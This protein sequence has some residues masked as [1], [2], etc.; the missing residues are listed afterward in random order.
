M[1]IVRNQFYLFFIIISIISVVSCKEVLEDD[2]RSVDTP[3]GFDIQ[4][5]DKMVVGET[6]QLTLDTGSRSA[7]ST[8]SVVWKSA[9]TNVATVDNTGVVTALNPGKAIISVSDVNVPDNH[10][11]FVIEVAPR[12]FV[13]SLQIEGPHTLGRGQKGQLTAKTLPP[14]MS[15]QSLIWT[16]ENEEIAKVDTS[17][18]VTAGTTLGETRIIVEAPTAPEGKKP[19]RAFWPIR[20]VGFSVVSEN[21]QNWL[22]LG[23]SITLQAALE[24]TVTSIQLGAL[25]WSSS[26]ADIVTV[27]EEGVATAVSHGVATI[28]AEDKLLGLAA[29]YTL[30]VVELAIVGETHIIETEHTLP[31]DVKV[32][33]AGSTLAPEVSWKSDNPSLVTLANGV[34][35]AGTEGG[36]ATITAE[37][38]ISGLSASYNLEVTTIHA[39]SL[40]LSGESEILVGADTPLAFQV[41]PAGAVQTEI[42]W[43]T[44]NENIAQVD[45]NGVVSGVSPGSV[46]ILAKIGGL[47]IAATHP[48][49][50]LPVEGESITI[51]GGTQ[52]TM[53][54]NIL[55]EAR[56][57]PENATYQEVIWKSS[58][59]AVA[60]VDNQGLV[61]GVSLGT[62]EIIAALK[63]NPQVESRV[64][65]TVAPVLV[66]SI[67]ISGKQEIHKADSVQLTATVFPENSTDQQVVWKTSNDMV[68]KV[69]QSG[70]VQGNIVG[71]ATITA[72]AVDGSGVA[73]EYEVTV[74]DFVLG[75]ELPRIMVVGDTVQ[76]LPA[77]LPERLAV[78]TNVT[79]LNKSPRVLSVDQSGLVTAKARGVGTVGALDTVSND[80]EW[81]ST[82]IVELVI[83]GA[84]AS[85]MERGDTKI[86]Y[87]QLL[88]AGVVDE[89]ISWASSNESVVFAFDD[90]E[91]TAK[92]GFGSARVVAI[93]RTTGAQAVH[94]IVVRDLQ[95]S[96]ADRIK[97]GETASSR[98][99]ANPA[100][101]EGIDL[102]VRWSSSNPEVASVDPVSGE[103]TGVSYDVGNPVTIT[104]E[105]NLGLVASY[106]IEVAPNPV[107]VEW[108]V[109]SGDSIGL[110]LRNET[111]MLLVDWNGD[112]EYVEANTFQDT[113]LYTS[114][115]KK[116]VTISANDDIVDLSDW[117]FG[118]FTR[119]RDKFT[120]VLQWGDAYMNSPRAAFSNA[121]KLVKFSAED[122]P[123]LEGS[124]EGMFAET[125]LFTGEGIGHWDMSNVTS[126]KN[127]FYWTK[128]FLGEEI[129]SWDVSSVT[130]MS[131]M[132]RAAEK[133]VGTELGNWDTSSLENMTWTFAEARVFNGDV[134]SWDISNVTNMVSSFARSSQFRQ[135]LSSWVVDKDLEMNGAF[136]GT[137]MGE[138]GY[139]DYHPV[140]C[141]KCY[142][143]HW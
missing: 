14:E 78:D 22:T 113:Y 74:Y 71:M 121:N 67:S 112:G 140:N 91:V 103:V 139:I 61:H 30:Y 133:F 116:I 83:D 92:G 84:S 108:T 4:G 70:M 2:T 100:K 33:P 124:L 120:D 47:D 31:L 29:S 99:M 137:K 102:S 50:V 10:D 20:V 46:E 39:E 122:S 34:V 57:S 24:N 130:D 135:D 73:A 142:A 89:N 23:S 123:R 111:N 95:V 82:T 21:N 98:I 131:F 45:S 90:G 143:G 9:N 136:T 119:S 7:T 104:A 118:S 28:T 134:G 68:A 43:S 65:V 63:H 55:L 26:N 76:I 36:F 96:G 13:T 114:G 77:T 19:A 38:K 8:I 87:A 25:S 129:G 117:S 5:V 27:S 85:F 60:T 52:L 16:S 44:S 48:V 109:N 88:P 79:W 128:S 17:G 35:T 49:K 58:N 6:T 97:V 53:G 69:S 94:T 127:M 3:Y 56:V 11:V 41:Y 18:L 54:D 101:V 106:T 86:L 110:P 107:V 64:A 125:A 42:V 37:D 72:E 115:G 80:Q 59:D 105:D 40:E 66:S 15:N 126:M 93:D 132:F 32:V 141:H 138:W 75:K 51:T 62:V 12:N 81:T 1:R